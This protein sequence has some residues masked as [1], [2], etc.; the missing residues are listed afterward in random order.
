M[1]TASQYSFNYLVLLLD[2]LGTQTAFATFVLAG[3]GAPFR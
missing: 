2:A 1:K 3:N